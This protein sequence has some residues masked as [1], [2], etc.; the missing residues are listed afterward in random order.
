MIFY[1]RVRRTSQ[2]G[3]REKALHLLL[4]CASEGFMEARTDRPR[5]KARLYED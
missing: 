1:A 5:K 4:E 3:R 2:T